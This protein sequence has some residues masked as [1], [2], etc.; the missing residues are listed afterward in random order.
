VR[1]HRR[2][3]IARAAQLA[4]GLV[5]FRDPSALPDQLI[6]FVTY[7]CNLACE[8]CFYWESLNRK[9]KEL[10]LEQWEQVSR[11]LD[12]VSQVLIS[13]GEP[14]L[15]RDLDDILATFYRNN[16]T[17]QIHLPTNALKTDITVATL[18]RILEKCPEMN[19]TLG[20][21][22][23]GLEETHDRIR[24]KKGSFQAVIE[25]SRAVAE[26]QRDHPRLRTY[27]INTVC[28]DNYDQVEPLARFV[29]DHMPVD[30]FGFSPVRG[31]PKSPTIEAPSADEWRD[32]AARLE[33]VRRH[34][35]ER[36]FGG[37]LKT[38]MLL[39]RAQYTHDIFGMVLEENRLPYQCRAGQVIGVIEPNGEVRLCE[40]TPIVGDL[41][42]VDF[43]F[44]KVWFAPAAAAM[45]EKIIG[46]SCSH[47]CFIGASLTQYPGQILKAYAGSVFSAT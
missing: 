30:D 13:G 4:K 40:L 22:M 25:T 26:L 1:Y 23:D 34:Y 47:A 28:R 11:S 29:M 3:V 39:S 5:R 18:T 43:D 7:V 2:D 42:D 17:R 35:A 12:E 36:R 41:R 44:R 15:R 10:T 6:L 37:G 21:S 38:R 14:F 19:V 27:V 46:C 31:Q 8:T 32:L 20:F 33:P 24:G 9:R 16:R 45:R